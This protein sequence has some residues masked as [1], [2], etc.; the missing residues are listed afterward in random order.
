MPAPR[1]RPCGARLRPHPP[2]DVGKPRHR[3]RHAL[4]LPGLPPPARHGVY[5][6]K[7]A[8][9]NSDG[10]GEALRTLFWLAVIDLP[11][12][13][14]ILQTVAGNN[15]TGQVTFLMYLTYLFLAGAAVLYAAVPPPA[16]SPTQSR[17]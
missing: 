4:P 14:I 12:I 13:F 6:F 7:H 17:S 16:S 9:L 1:H 11:L 10:V 2:W 15:P 5:A 8:G 3:P